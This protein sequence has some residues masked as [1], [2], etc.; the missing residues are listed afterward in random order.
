[1]YKLT[2]S[3][4]YQIVIP[5]T[6]DIDIG[7][8]WTCYTGWRASV[9]QRHMSLADLHGFAHNLPGWCS[10][11][12]A[13]PEHELSSC[14][15][16]SASGRALLQLRLE[17]ACCSCSCS[18]S[19]MRSHCEGSRRVLVPGAS[20]RLVIIRGSS[21]GRT[22]SFGSWVCIRR[23]KPPMAMHICKWNRCAWARIGREV[24]ATREPHYSC[25][26]TQA[27]EWEV[28]ATGLFD[29]RIHT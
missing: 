29:L 14:W 6:A 28:V 3:N 1:M 24:M 20:L 4:V 27:M 2:P 12:V 5:R 10:F 19:S 21:I 9:T 13:D 15:P 22:V 23:V 18:T 26:I 8:L 11:V 25:N 7:N 17:A 16:L